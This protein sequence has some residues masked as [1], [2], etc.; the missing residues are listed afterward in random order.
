[1]IIAVDFDGT[2]V[3]HEYPRIGPDVPW[4]EETLKAC[5]ARGDVL[6][7]WTMRSHATL[8]AAVQWF[9]DK[10]LPLYGVNENPD[11]RT[12]TS[13]P[14]VLAHVYI[15]DAA[16]GCPLTPQGYVDWVRVRELLGV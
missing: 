7:L 10:G 2:C 1:M 5:V 6:I 3:E 16:L 9:R 13:S 15:D 14:K 8:D 11:Q 4:A 12:W